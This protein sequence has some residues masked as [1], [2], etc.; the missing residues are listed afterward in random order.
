MEDN[1]P[2]ET[3]TNIRSILGSFLFSGDDAEKKV[4][5]LS[6]GERA[7]LAMACMILR[8]S[9]LI[10][11]DEPTNHLDIQS[12]EVLKKAL[13]DYDGTLIIVSHDREFLQG[14]CTK[15]YEFVD[16]NV[17]EYLGDINYFLD[18]KKLND[19]RDIDTQKVKTEVVDTAAQTKIDFEEQKKIKRRI[20]IIEKDIEKLEK[21]LAEIMV[22]MNDPN[23]Y[24][25]SDFDKSNKNYKTK[26]DQLTSLM[27]E[28][29]Q[30]IEKNI[31]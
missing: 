5:V 28:W 23:F 10:I 27:E 19:I 21:D 18:K 20:S 17:K 22:K 11:M 15:V 16:K 24:M 7:R 1:A 13:A 25:S 12:K 30:L 6:G 9:S 29:E 26:S 14:L 8:P 2:P 31:T 4:S 3:R